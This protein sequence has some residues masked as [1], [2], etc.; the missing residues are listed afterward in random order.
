M[1]YSSSFQYG[2]FILSSDKISF[3][4]TDSFNR[5]GFLFRAVAT[6]FFQTDAEH[7][8]TCTQLRGGL[9]HDIIGDTVIAGDFGGLWD[10]SQK[11]QYWLDWLNKKPFTT[12][13]VDGNHE[14]FDR[15]YS[16]PIEK[17]NGGN[18]HK[19]RPSVIHLMRGQVFQLCGKKF[20]VFGG[21]KSHDIDG[22]I[23]DPEAPDFKKKKKELDKEWLPYRVNHISWWKEE[24]A[25]KEEMEEGLR[26]LSQY[27]NEVDFIIS[28]CCATSTQK[29]FVDKTFSADSMTD[30]LELVKQR[31]NFKKWFFGH[32]HDNKNI[33]PREIL[34]YEQIIRIL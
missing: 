9:H 24:M 11:D 2:Y 31:V 5:K 17:W 1:S 12:L 33:G 28:H 26:N 23:L 32:Y 29:Q 34:I 27:N 4:T 19:I 16:Y 10:G 25:S 8:F 13:F 14:N 22:G 21:A 20:F 3:V 7:S 18:V 15:L 30:Y 6:P